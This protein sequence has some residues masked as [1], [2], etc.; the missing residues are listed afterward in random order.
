MPRRYLLC[1]LPI[2]LCLALGVKLNAA[3]VQPAAPP[4]QTGTLLQIRCDL[5][6]ELEHPK[7]VVKGYIAWKIKNNTGGEN[8][9]GETFSLE[10]ANSI[11]DLPLK[12]IIPLNADVRIGFTSYSDSSFKSRF[13]R[14][15]WF[16]RCRIQDE[17]SR[18]TLVV[19]LSSFKIRK[20]LNIAPQA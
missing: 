9:Q 17:S 15:E 7:R 4:R 18:K 10:L 19:N 16:S 20:K 12:E 1:L 8:V 5:T 13:T 3:Q 2:G 6:D 11:V 14:G